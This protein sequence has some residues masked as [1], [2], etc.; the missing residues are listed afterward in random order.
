[1]R[2]QQDIA[3]VK[4]ISDRQANDIM[5]LN[6]ELRNRPNVDPNVKQITV[7]NN[8]WNKYNPSFFYFRK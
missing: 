3:H 8:F 1:M 7:L 2:M 4:G 5:M 6:N